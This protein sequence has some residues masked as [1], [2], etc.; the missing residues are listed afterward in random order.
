MRCS[1]KLQNVGGQRGFGLVEM[2]VSLAILLTVSSVCFALFGQYVGR[3]RLQTAVST[4]SSTVQLA[5][6]QMLHE[7][8]MAGYPTPALM[9]AAGAA[10]F[11]TAQPSAITFETA[12][13]PTQP[14]VDQVSYSLN[15]NA[16]IRT[17]TPK[18]GSASTSTTL[19]TGVTSLQFT[20]LDQNNQPTTTPAQ[21]CGVSVA[22]TVQ[23]Q[24]SQAA[25]QSM[26]VP[27]QG[28][29]FARNLCHLNPGS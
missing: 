2:M 27:M 6:N 20:Y 10:G 21:V 18:G 29:A 28:T 5:L 14:T 25:G 12:L 13:D 3:Y 7:I 17:V 16:L 22:M 26:D 19:A 23:A 11:T 4:S 24:A 8:R 15:G 1:R 9:G